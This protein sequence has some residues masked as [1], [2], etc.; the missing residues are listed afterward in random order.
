MYQ[1][2]VPVMN[3]TVHKGTREEYLRQFRAAGVRRVFL[4]PDTDMVT[5]TVRS[6]D[7]LKEN[8]A[9]FSANGLLVGIWVGETVGHG[10]LLHD[11]ETKNADE[12]MTPLVNFAG[13]ERPGTRC[14]LDPRFQRNVAAVFSRL[15]TAGAD[16]ILIDDDFRLSQHGK[17][18]YCCLC[19]LHMERINALCKE[20]LTRKELR[21]KILCGK[22]NPH[23][24][25][26]LQASGD[27]L[28]ELARIL[29]GAVDEVDP[30]IGLALCSCHCV[31]DSD[32]VDPLELTEI[33][34]GQH[35]PV[36]RLLGAP[37]WHVR[38]DKKLPATFEIARMMASFCRDSGYELMSEG[39]AY[40]RPRYHVPAALVELQDALIQAEQTYTTSFKYLFDYTAP[41]T[42]ETGSVARHVRDLPLLSRLRESFAQGEQIGVRVAIRPHLLKDTDC[43][44]STPKMLSPYPTAGVLMGYCAIPTTYSGRP[45]CHAAFGVNA[46]DLTEE[47][48]SQGV[49]LD[50]A[51]AILL[52]E[53]G[54]DVGLSQGQDLRA[55][56]EPATV[57]FLLPAQRDWRIVS[58]DG[59]C[60]LLKVSPA[61]SAL[62]LLYG[63][64]GAREHLLCYRY[65]NA[66]GQRFL[67][68]LFDGMSLHRDSGL[69]KGYLSQSVVTEGVEWISRRPLPAKCMGHPSLYL[70][71]RQSE[72]ALLVGLFNCHADS[73]PAPTVE[74]ND[75]YKALECLNA[76]GELKG[77]Q[78]IL[79]EI[80][81]YSWASFR[82]E[83]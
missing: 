21:D 67:V 63:A 30:S 81:A 70:M 9:Y 56:L 68:Y 57:S 80:P 13:E 53:R 72:N 47:Q 33:L 54:V 7:L 45:L 25:A 39:D 16:L 22:P 65:E 14:P 26:Y 71:C 11:T 28:R 29:R 23:R 41:P 12:K 48:L 82:V 44:L 46:L 8:I 58:L 15:A 60:R 51:S 74:L 4:V 43:E 78:V 24:D 19:P 64:E 61:P 37:Y 73:I 20:K 83:R 36:L 69:L 42:Y 79:S 2:S 66:K 17:E 55:S 31:W 75:T 10:G 5:G 59:G 34:K 76:T 1:L 32:G 50:A 40:P 77:D 35:P 6:F 18:E 52:T 27:S 38:T 3:A 62:P 49:I